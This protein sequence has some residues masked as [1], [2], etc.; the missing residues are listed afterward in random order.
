VADKS[1]RTGGPARTVEMVAETGGVLILTPDSP[2]SFP[3]YQ[4]KIL[5]SEGRL[6]GT[7]EDLQKNPRDDTFT[8]WIPPGGLAPGDYRVE[9]HGLSGESAEVI[10]G[11]QIRLLG[12]PEAPP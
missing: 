6:V 9:L 5:D 12:P 2:G 1:E 4:A 8:L 11:Y 7:I 10:A 3:A